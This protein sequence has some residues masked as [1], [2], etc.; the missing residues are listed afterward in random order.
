MAFG[1]DFHAGGAVLGDEGPAV[2]SF[3]GDHGTALEDVVHE[4]LAVT[5]GGDDEGE[6]GGMR[7]T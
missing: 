6:G 4:A 1:E 3:D 5:E 7:W 2:A